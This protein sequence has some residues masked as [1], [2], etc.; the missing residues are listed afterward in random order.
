[1]SAAL[2]SL[3]DSWISAVP[4]R[5]R[6]TVGWG[7]LVVL[8]LVPVVVRGRQVLE[9][10]VEVH[11]VGDVPVLVLSNLSDED[12][13]ELALHVDARYLASRAHLPAG[14]AWRLTPDALLD[15]NA[16]LLGRIDPYYAGLDP[17]GETGSAPA[18]Y[19]PTHL[20]FTVGSGAA[21]RTAH[22]EVPPSAPA[23]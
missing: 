3:I 1:M 16:W 5:V 15:S 14:L 7:S 12:W 20:V 21:R 4:P 13:S 8:G 19:R 9:V 23:P 6:L 18:N 22:L 2:R 17:N 11:T 10:G